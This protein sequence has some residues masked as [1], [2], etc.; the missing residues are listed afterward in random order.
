MKV[1]KEK[2]EKLEKIISDK[3]VKIS[4]IF[5]TIAKQNE[6]QTKL[7]NALA[8]N[9]DQIGNLEANL[10]KSSEKSGNY[11]IDHQKIF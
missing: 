4:S 9:S 8:E 6:T 10:D 1:L 7:S 2:V 5:E 3:D 11:K